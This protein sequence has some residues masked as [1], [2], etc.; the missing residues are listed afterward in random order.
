MLVVTRRGTPKERARSRSG[1]VRIAPATLQL[2]SSY[3][4][5]GE[6]CSFAQFNRKLASVKIVQAQ[7]K[8]GYTFEYDYAAEKLRVLQNGAEVAP[9]TNLATTPGIVSIL[10]LSRKEVSR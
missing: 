5:G 1:H 4:A 2:S 9:G 7:P 3:P 8:D 10:A 6:P